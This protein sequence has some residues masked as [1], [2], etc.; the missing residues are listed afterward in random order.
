MKTKLMAAAILAASLTA[1]EV[2]ACNLYV[3]V[4]CPNDNTAPNIA[5]CA[6]SSDGT[7]TTCGMTDATGL[8]HLLL[9]K[10]DT[11]TICVDPT[12]LPAGATIKNG[13]LCQRMFVPEVGPGVSVE[14]TLGGSFCGSTPPPGMCWMT[15]GGNIGP[16][17]T[18]DFSYGGV[19]YPGCSPTAAGGGNWNV[20]DHAGLH[21]TGENIVVND[22]FGP[23][24]G[25]PKVTVR[26]IDFSGTGEI[27]GP[28]G[29]IPVTF[30]GRAIDNHDGGAGSDQLYLQVIDPSSNTVVML[31]GT[32][33]D[34]PATVSTGNIQIHQSS[35]GTAPVGPTSPAN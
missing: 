25:S 32:S 23:P 13:H 10:A 19:V 26:V 15:G 7:S 20:V 11:Y 34:H 18:P 24:T 27:A 8:V 22:C 35:C 6:T 33:A 9:P 5:V 28:T 17:K 14:F 31:I 12:T 30:V 2:R 1:V 4:I 21:F 3:T 29:T 16:G